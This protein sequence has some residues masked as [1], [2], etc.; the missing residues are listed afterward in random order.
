MITLEELMPSLQILVENNLSL[1]C[2]SVFHTLSSN[3]VELSE[4]AESI[5]HMIL[6]EID[7]A[8]TLQHLCHGVMYALPKS[9]VFLLVKLKD[10]IVPIT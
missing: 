9:R 7:P 10:Q 4:K 5:T 3:R 2:N 6:E 1:I 8:V